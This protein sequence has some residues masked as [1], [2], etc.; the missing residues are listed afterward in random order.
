MLNLQS[1]VRVYNGTPSAGGV[2]IGTAF[3]INSQLL[4]TAKHVVEDSL[5]DIYLDGTPGGGKEKIAVDNIFPCERDIAILKANLNFPTITPLD[6]TYHDLSVFERVMLAGYFDEIQSLHQVKSEISGH[7]STIHTWRSN[8]KLSKG[9]SGGPVLLEGSNKV[10][11]IIQARDV[12][13]NITYLIPSTE[14]FN[15][16]E[17]HNFL[18]IQSQAPLHYFPA[19]PAHFLARKTYLLTIKKML[20]KGISPK[21]G[22]VGV[23]NLIA[24]QGMVGVGKSTLAMAVAHDKQIRQIFTDGIVYVKLGEKPNVIQSQTNILDVFDE[25]D[26][27]VVN[28]SQGNRLLG[29]YL[30][31]KNI[32]LILDDVW[33]SEDLHYFSVTAP[34]LMILFTTRD[35]KI[36]KECSAEYLSITPLSFDQALMLLSKQTRIELD[37]M[38]P[39]AQLIVK[40]C[41]QLPL[42][43][44]MIG[45][46][47]RNKPN[48]R[49]SR[50]LKYLKNAEL[51]NIRQKFS[52]Y[53]YPDLFKA[54]H[55]SVEALPALIQQCY[56]ELAVFPAGA[57]LPESIL[58]IY[59]GANNLQHYDPVDI[60]DELLD[61]SLI[62]RY[63]DDS[64]ILHDLQRAYVNS[65]CQN[66]ETCHRNLIDAF[67]K[68]YPEGLHTIPYNEP[69]FY[70]YTHFA[71][72]LKKA[73]NHEYSIKIANDLLQKQPLLQ[74]RKVL[75]CASL[76]DITPTQAASAVIQFSDSS[77]TIVQCLNLLGDKARKEAHRII[78]SRKHID[79][80]S[81]CIKV[82]GDDAKDDARQLLTEISDPKTCVACLKLLGSEAKKNAKQ[83]IKEHQDAEVI[84]ACLKILKD[85]ACDDA[86]NIIQKHQ[87]PH[88]IIACMKVLGEDGKVYARRLILEHQN[89]DVITSCLRLLGDE[90]KS[91]ARRFLK[92]GHSKD[93]LIACL[94]LLGDEA[95]EDA[96]RLMGKHKNREI[97]LACLK[98]LGID[99]KTEAKRLIK[100]Q[101]DPN[102]VIAC[103]RILG[104]EA[105]QFVKDKLKSSEWENL[106]TPLKTIILKV[107]LKTSVREKRAI[108][109]L[110]NW[111]S[112]D[113]RLVH[114]ALMVFVDKP[115]K[116][117]VYCRQVMQNWETDIDYCIIKSIPKYSSHIVSSMN[118]PHLLDMAIDLSSQMLDKERKEIG[119][120]DANLVTHAE[121]ILEKAEQK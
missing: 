69:P 110:E 103:L 49:W 23:S 71:F 58:E 3:F 35:E 59:W 51:Q 90:A 102:V 47:L 17:K 114:A 87:D 19:L 75:R 74:W 8:G 105:K 76:L 48:N 6:L 97:S 43:I 4:I 111:K 88:V 85:G 30:S 32:L 33:R 11:G 86:H 94:N 55:V 65:Q 118:H 41:G 10:V 28:K 60:I 98:I 89:K 38:P 68:K 5:N 82:L 57:V 115:E 7:V 22:A 99:G 50:V 109:I 46:M 106:H 61:V 108:E 21:K 104:S 29:K 91:D 39:E 9:M 62:F 27:I 78:K 101:Q 56:L 112:F 66:I 36:P 13:K 42:A 121:T 95:K 83:L 70:F 67:V 113:R 24:L 100:H 96:L 18:D 120:L 20:L 15:E 93:V 1:I 12:D 92:E 79:A 84:I 14:I 116:T 52:H 25:F 40:D 107:P 45:A 81:A 2:F 80:I 16:L 53:D 72:H 54:L 119:Y 63:N 26:E 31:Q 117:E 73:K 77:N 34:S 64:L 37:D 44:C